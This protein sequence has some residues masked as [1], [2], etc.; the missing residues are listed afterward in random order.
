MAVAGRRNIL[1]VDSGADSLTVAATLEKAGFRVR[2]AR[3]SREGFDAIYTDPPQCL[4][5]AYTP[6]GELGRDLLAEMKHDTFYGH[7]PVIAMLSPESLEQGVDWMETPA[8]D[9]LVK[10]LTEKEIITRVQLC[11]ARANRD[12]DANP[13]TGLPGNVAIMRDAET[14]ISAAKPFAMAYLDIDAFKAYNDKYGFARGDEVLRMTARV[15]VNAIRSLN[16]PETHVG[17]LGGDD[18]V[19]ITPSG[20]MQDA[21]R[22]IVNDFDQ[23]VTN[24]YDKEDRQAGGIQSVDRQGNMQRF[25]FLTC[26][27][28]VVDTEQT[29]VRHVAD[30]SARAAEIKVY[31]KNLKGSNFVIDRRKRAGA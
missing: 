31:A 2:T 13:L 16:S 30:L 25:P 26:S 20:M 18:F 11:L 22:R 7:I 8:D 21:C 24:F 29:P 3:T 1:V 9:Y 19:F 23:I 12:I 27:I 5:I 15:L 28:A 6:S 4:L 14:R 17:H 10:P